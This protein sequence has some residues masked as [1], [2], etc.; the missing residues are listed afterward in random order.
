LLLAGA[1]LY[2]AKTGSEDLAGVAGHR[3][4]VA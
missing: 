4:T 3:P 2:V 1:E